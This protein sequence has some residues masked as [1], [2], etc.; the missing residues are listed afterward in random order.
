MNISFSPDQLY[1]KYRPIVMSYISARIH[2]EEDAEDLCGD[3]FVK[4][5][6]MIESYDEKIASISTILYKITHDAVID[7]Y[8]RKREYD[9]LS[10]DHAVLPSSEDIIMDRERADELIKALSKLPPQQRDI[11]ILRFYRGWTLVRIA[12]EMGLSY[13]KVVSRQNSAFKTLRR[14]LGE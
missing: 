14:M 5:F 13:N 7:Y 9:E 3:V 12:E 4:L 6:G 10:E 8:R 2:C 11:L 1:K